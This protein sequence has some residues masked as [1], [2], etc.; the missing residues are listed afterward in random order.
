MQNYRDSNVYIYTLAYI[1]I[2]I[3]CIYTRRHIHIYVY[4]HTHIQ[5]E[6]FHWLVHSP[7][8]CS[9]WCWATQKPG[10]SVQD[11]HVDISTLNTWAVCHCFPMWIRRGR[12][13]PQICTYWV[14]LL[15]ATAQLCCTIAVAPMNLFL[16]LFSLS[17]LTSSCRYYRYGSLAQSRFSST[18]V[19]S[20]IFHWPYA[21]N[22]ITVWNWHFCVFIL[23]KGKLKI[24]QSS[25]F[26]VQLN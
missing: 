17:F 2:Y 12:G 4:T 5:R 9:G 24:F 8:G 1:H 18:L 6:I 23:G 3:K 25:W 7:S 16:I 13:G 10:D 22:R 21:T 26:H 15:Q 11:S 20:H 19:S 14:P